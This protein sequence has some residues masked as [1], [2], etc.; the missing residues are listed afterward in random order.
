MI[1]LLIYFAYYEKKQCKALLGLGLR[2]Q[3]RWG[4]GV[5]VRELTAGRPGVTIKEKTR[6]GE[7]WKSG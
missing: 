5:R 7:L 6:T 2:R 3:N 4:C 1:L